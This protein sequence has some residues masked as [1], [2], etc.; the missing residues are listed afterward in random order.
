MEILHVLKEKIASKLSEAYDAQLSSGEVIINPT[1]KDVSGDLTVV[2]FPYV[3]RFKTS[4]QAIGD[5]LKNDLLT[6]TQVNEVELA[7]GFLN[8]TLSNSYWNDVLL[9]I[10]QESNYG[11]HP[12]SGQKILVEFSEY[13]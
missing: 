9:G 12:K 6:L 1:R 2:L 10:H 3:K 7:G 5:T 11:I 8:L 4:P 13:Q